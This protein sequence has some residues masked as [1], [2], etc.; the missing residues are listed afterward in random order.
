M[1]FDLSKLHFQPAS[2]LALTLRAD[3]LSA[4]CVRA[5]GETP[6]EPIKIAV[7]ADA[8]LAD[9][10]KAGAALAAALEAAGIKERRCALALPPSWVLSTSADLPE[11][12]P[13]DLRGYFELRAEREFSIPDLVLAHDTYHVGTPRATLAAL[14]PKRMEA[15]SA[16]LAAAGCRTLSISLDLPCALDH[17]EPTLHLIPGQN[18]VE[19]SITCGGGTAAL[20]TIS[21]EPATLARELRITLGRLPEAVRTQLKRARIYGTPD[22][23][24]T[25]LL[26]KLGITPAE[27]DCESQAAPGAARL[28]L[29]QTPVPFEFF[30]PEANRW[31]ET[32]KRFNT[33]RGRKAVA[34]AAVVVFLPILAFSFRSHQEASLIREWATL[35]PSV[36]ELDTIQQKIRQF[37]PWFDPAPQKLDALRSVIAAFPERGDLWTRSVQ[38]SPFVEKSDAGGRGAPSSTAAMVTI[39]GFAQNNASLMSL[40]GTLS[41]QA[42]V[43]ALQ[44]KQLRGNNPSQFSLTFKWETHHD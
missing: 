8:V 1:T 14:P 33:T 44:V 17:P 25:A 31:K 41:K 28:L 36:A 22:E 43:S 26:E 9:P 40:Q 35:K 4:L 12:S 39:N 29:N 6:P 24:L 19:L 23:A 5:S 10:A 38:I 3:S 30:T 2:I 37:R 27:N 11:V 32:F 21:A 16:F 15:A 18:R 13:E 20:R 34:S 7:G 42:G